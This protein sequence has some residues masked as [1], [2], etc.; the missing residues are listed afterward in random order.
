[1]KRILRTNLGEEGSLLVVT[2]LVLFA[3]S[4]IGA[5]LAMVASMDLRIS[6]NQRRTVQSLFV[7]EAGLNEAIH[8]LAL[9]DPTDVTV[10]GWTGNAAIADKEPYDPN[11]TTRIYL[12]S[13]A[14]APASSGS[15]FSTGTLQDVTRPHLD[16]S[17]KSGTD[18]VI[19]IR[20]K[21]EDRNGDGVRDTNEIV[22]YD[23][24]AVPPENFTNGYPIEIVTVT[25]RSAEGESII[26][27]EVTKKSI[28]VRTL[29]ALY[30]DKDVS[31]TGNSAFCG[32]DHSY[33]TPHGS[34]PGGSGAWGTPC[35]GFHKSNGHLPGVTATG[36]QVKVWGS[37]TVTGNPM[38]VNN[39]ASNPFYSLDE[40]LGLPTSDVK[41]MLAKADNKGIVDPLNGITYIVGDAK[42]NS[43]LVGEGLIYVTGDLHASGSFIFKGLIYVEG[44][45]HFTGS[46]WILGSMIVR[47]T[48]SF[49]FSSG[50]AVALYSSEALTRAL[51][52][53]MPALVLSWRE[54]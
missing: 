15:I 49:N 32:Y 22:R 23:K 20:H 35:S 42:I 5:T 19:T 14:S 43:N 9:P 26:Q 37:S 12:T 34:V 36:D 8:R 28:L 2:L 46:P 51:S 30:V 24:L 52:S 44:D 17:V 45:V 40:A 27:A 10:G 11:W 3:I 53:S 4:V 54:M 13:P 41:K 25:G 16:Y 47:G 1:M 21:W 38:P 33:D 7:A 50:H 48:T 29:G 39:D 31:L 6:G 18:G